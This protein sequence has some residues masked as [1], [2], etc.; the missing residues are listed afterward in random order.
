METNKIFHT[1]NLPLWFYIDA[2]Y[3]KAILINANMLHLTLTF[4][5]TELSFQCKKDFSP[6]NPGSR[7]SGWLWGH[8][9]NPWFIYFPAISLCVLYSDYLFHLATLL[10][11]NWQNEKQN[12]IKLPIESRHC[13]L[14]GNKWTPSKH[15]HL[16]VGDL[17]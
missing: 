10:K 7:N 2:K 17:V 6:G 8:F 5:C 1:P 15:H 16:T 12:H 9:L 3:I 14:N 13:V 4:V 11:L